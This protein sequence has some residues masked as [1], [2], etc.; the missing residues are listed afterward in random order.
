[1]KKSLLLIGAVSMMLAASSAIMHAEVVDRIIV[2]VNNEVITQGEVDRIL[3]PLYQQYKT[4]FAED[5]L[6]EKLDEARQAIISQLIDEKLVLCEAKKQNIEVDDKDLNA[7]LEE[8]KRRFPSVALFE[9]ALAAQKISLK[10]LKNR[11]R[12]Q[13]MSKK[14]MEQKVGSRLS[15]ATP[16][17]I[18][19][20]YNKHIEDFSSPE[21]LKLSNILVKLKEGVDPKKSAE[22]ATEISRRLKAGEDFAELAKIYSDGPGAQEGGAMG[23]VKKGD[24]LPEIEKAVFSLKEGETSDVIQTSLGYHFFKLTGRKE[25]HVMSPVEVSRSIEEIIWME[26]VKEKSKEWVNDL[27]KN[28]YIAFK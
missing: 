7:K 1:M 18:S 16:N 28:A 19:D 27:R 11:Y 25:S 24:L 8:T 5:Q 17:E 21:E 4:M 12:D 20:Y 15:A 3:G 10:E 2:V 22:L 13:L 26:K 23:Y 14:L 9:Q 6:I